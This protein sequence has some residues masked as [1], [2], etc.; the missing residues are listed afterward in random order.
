MR[1]REAKPFT[2]D[3]EWLTHD[4]EAWPAL[5]LAKNGNNCTGSL[6]CPDYSRCFPV[7]YDLEKG[8]TF[9]TPDAAHW[10]RLEP[11]LDAAAHLGEATEL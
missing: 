10:D 5:V 3:D 1:R 11:L 4:K 7:W 6:P 2:E 8:N 9:C